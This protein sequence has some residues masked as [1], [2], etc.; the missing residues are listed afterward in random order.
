MYCT[1]CTY[2]DASLASLTNREK[3]RVLQSLF[4]RDS[5]LHWVNKKET[6]PIQSKSSVIML[7]VSWTRCIWLYLWLH[8]VE[9]LTAALRTVSFTENKTTNP[10]RSNAKFHWMWIYSQL[11][12]V[13]HHQF[14]LEEHKQCRQMWKNGSV[15]PQIFQFARL[16]SQQ[17]SCAGLRS[18]LSAV[19]GFGESKGWS[20][21]V[22]MQELFFGRVPK[23]E[24]QNIKQMY[25]SQIHK[26]ILYIYTYWKHMQLP[27]SI[28]EP[29]MIEIQAWHAR[30]I[31]RT[32]LIVSCSF[33]ANVTNGANYWC[34]SGWTLKKKLFCPGKKFFQITLE[35][36]L[37]CHQKKIIP[38]SKRGRGFHL[39]PWKKN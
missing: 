28:W 13:H 26:C 8:T 24:C 10:L 38:Q 1:H 18:K 5:L 36:K 12:L 39:G 14:L 21:D 23:W 30:V 35:K 4:E 34:V 25:V 37:F 9:F 6:N 15:F 17:G 20:C 31:T 22:K 3:W 29:I 16:F 33:W 11:F 7:R 19:G 32:E 2:W 27:T